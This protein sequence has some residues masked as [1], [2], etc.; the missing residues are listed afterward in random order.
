MRS[1]V[2][3]VAVAVEVFDE[4]RLERSLRKLPAWKQVAFMALLGARMIPNYR[5]FSA[6]T[7]FGNVSVLEEAFDAAWTWIES[8]KSPANLTALLKACERQAP[9]TED[10]SSPYTSAALDAASVAEI[11]LD[12][13]ERPDQVRLTEAATL[14]RDTVDMFVR[15]L[16]DLDSNALGLEEALRHPLMQRELRQQREDME[17]LPQAS[18]AAVKLGNGNTRGRA[19][20]TV[21]S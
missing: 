14:A 20:V 2:R 7:V 21:R 15:V 9:D 3:E 6:E 10:F 19:I 5:R 18:D 8:G 12:A 17:M 13:I 1:L 11:T 4:K 16:L